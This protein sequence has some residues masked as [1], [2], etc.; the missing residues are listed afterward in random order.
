MPEPPPLKVQANQTEIG[1]T[2]TFDEEELDDVEGVI[3]RMVACLALEAWKFAKA[4]R[5]KHGTGKADD[6]LNCSDRL[7]EALTRTR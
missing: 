6:A 2:R 4:L 5:C 7:A 1:W 3:E